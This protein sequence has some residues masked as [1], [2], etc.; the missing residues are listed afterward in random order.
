MSHLRKATIAALAAVVLAACGGSDVPGV[1]ESLDSTAA[2]CVLDSPLREVG[3]GRDAPGAPLDVS[4]PAPVGEADGACRENA[5]FRVGRGLQDITGPAANKSGA[6]WEDPTQVMRGI[7]QRQFARAFVFASPCN[8]KRAVFVSADIGLMWGSLRSGVLDALAAD[9]ELAA[10]YG[11]ENVMLSATHTHNGP[12]GYAHVEAG[13]ALHLGYDVLV[14]ETIVDGIV[15]AI[16]RAHADIEAH[17]EP[18]PIHLADGALRDTNINRSK[19][20]YARNS[21]A[22]RA[23]FVNQRGEEVDVNKRMLQLNLHRADGAPAGIIN[24]FAV[25]P[26]IV[27]PE[28]DLVSPDMKGFAALGFER[29]M[30][31]GPAVPDA[32]APFVA[33]FAQADSGDA[34][35]NIFIEE[36]PH[37]DPA[38]GGGETVYES[39]AISGTK[40]LARAIELWEA[41]GA[42]LRGPVD[43]RFT[44]VRMNDVAVTDEAVLAALEH[45]P[46][47]DSADKRTCNAALGV[48]FPAGAEDGPGP[49]SEE[50]L[51]CD[52]D[53]ALLE[54]VAE[55]F[56]GLTE[57]ALPLKT[58]SA[59]LLCNLDQLPLLGLGCHAEKPVLL[60][61]NLGESA[62]GLPE[63]ILELL[64]PSLNFETP[65]E[66]FQILRVGNL[67]ILGLPWE[68]TTMSGRRLRRLMLEALAP[69][70]VDTVIV[71]GLVNDYTHYLT[72]RAEYASQQY[73]GASTVYGPWSLA[74]V[75]QETR[76]LALSMR[77]GDDIAAGPDFPRPVPLLRRPSYVASDLPAG[78]GFGSV[79]AD[80]PEVAGRGE[81]VRARFQAGHPRNEL[82]LGGS[83]VLVEREA[84]DGSWE[85]VARDRDPELR[86]RWEP[87][88]A[89]PLPLDVPPTGPSTLEA[90]WHVP[91]DAPAG[92]YRLRH[93]GVAAPGGAYEGVSSAFRLEGEAAACP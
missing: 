45:P 73:E 77:D 71:A 13:N 70:G 28:A 68:V 1:G 62:G 20:A 22:E 47:L 50:G 29:L 88:A 51:S 40:H 53:P 4:P 81:I 25:H 8:G 86:F 89:V 2:R 41:G 72:T 93:S 91:A 74:A 27:G 35:P 18:A 64:G 3:A 5:R 69:A 87:A 15:A 55:D 59:L 42:P 30:G 83:Y 57:L 23:A 9:A 11:A 34:S 54:A 79:V 17:P 38:R 66:P 19:P 14:H 46:E 7:H 39:T 75:Q 6:G 10:H 21:A 82:R 52:A 60:P 56:A 43:Y 49:I 76:R 65:V 36:F 24:W 78:E 26:T 32:E 48:S 33:A 80:V 44:H 16:D 58:V 67:A 37:P 61:L 90:V 12:A 31:A 84:A 85:T 63:R 92:R